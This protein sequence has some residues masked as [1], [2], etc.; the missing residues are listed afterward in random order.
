MLEQKTEVAPEAQRAP[1][2]GRLCEYC[3]EPFEPTRRDQKFCRPSCRAAA[4]RKER[5]DRRDRAG[6]FPGFLGC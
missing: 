4:S 1:S 2:T 6:Y 5:E 3:G